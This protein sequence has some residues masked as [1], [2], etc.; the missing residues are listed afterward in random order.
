[1][2]FSSTK[3]NQPVYSNEEELKAD[4]NFDLIEKKVKK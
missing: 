2:V 3:M 1:M 4:L